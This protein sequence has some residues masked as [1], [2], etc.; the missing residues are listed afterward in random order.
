MVPWLPLA[1]KRMARYYLSHRLSETTAAENNPSQR[2]EWM[3]LACQLDN[4]REHY[5]HPFLKR[6]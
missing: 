1:P 2:S 3:H 4:Q 6:Y 5:V